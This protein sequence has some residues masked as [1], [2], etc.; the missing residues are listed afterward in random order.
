MLRWR[1]LYAEEIVDDGPH[2][3]VLVAGL[4]A[5]DIKNHDPHRPV[6]GFRRLDRK[7]EAKATFEVDAA[8]GWLERSRE[9]IRAKFYCAGIP[10]ELIVNDAV[11]GSLAG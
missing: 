10:G 5:T 3:A 9:P 8:H 4:P 1:V 6:F 7:R 11:A 2:I